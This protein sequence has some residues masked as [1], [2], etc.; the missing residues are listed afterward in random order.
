MAPWPI[1]LHRDPLRIW[2]AQLATD[3][4]GSSPGARE[5]L[6]WWMAALGLHFGT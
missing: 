5:R 3:L 1:A 4:Q 6:S 2:L